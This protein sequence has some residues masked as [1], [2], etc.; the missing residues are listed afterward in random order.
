M[1][2]DA[3]TVDGNAIY[4]YSILRLK[5]ALGHAYRPSDVFSAN[6]PSYS[7]SRHNDGLGQDFSG[8]WWFCVDSPR[9][10][11][12]AKK[13]S[14]CWEFKTALLE[15]RREILAVFVGVLP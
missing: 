13:R 15:R 1:L 7:S 12:T 4:I 5:L 8:S 9:P 6:H 10:S 2:H 3:L 14:Y 11:A